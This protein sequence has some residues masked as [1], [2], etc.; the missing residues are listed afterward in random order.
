MLILL[1]LFGVLFMISIS[2]PGPIITPSSVRQGIV[3]WGT[4]ILFALLV[5]YL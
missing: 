1:L 4:L 3:A 2:S 5:K